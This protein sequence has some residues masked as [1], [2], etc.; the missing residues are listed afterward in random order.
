MLPLE[1]KALILGQN[2]AENNP[3][4]YFLKDPLPPSGG[5]FVIDRRKNKRFKKYVKSCL[6]TVQ[7][8]VEYSHTAATTKI[9]IFR[10]RKKD[11]Q[12]IYKRCLQI[13]EIVIR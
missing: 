7:N 9:Q 11:L 3:T 8:M 2:K 4:K 6:Q 5:F 12:K 10:Q 1:H 13:T